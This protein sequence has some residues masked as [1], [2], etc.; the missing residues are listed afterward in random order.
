ME[1]SVENIQDLISFLETIK[2]KHGNLPIMKEYDAS[3]YIGCDIKVSKERNPDNYLG[4]KIDVVF[5]S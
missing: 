4:D 3:Y 2:E 5:I 1:K